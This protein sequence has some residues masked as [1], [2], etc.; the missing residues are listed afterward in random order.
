MKKESSKTPSPYSHRALRFKDYRLKSSKACMSRP[1]DI[2][3]AIFAPHAGK[4]VLQVA[5]I[6]VAVLS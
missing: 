4:A 3:T 2:N 5:A 6:E 1:K